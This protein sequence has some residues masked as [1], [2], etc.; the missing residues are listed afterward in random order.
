MSLEQMIGFSLALLVMAVG[1]AGSV[2]PGVPST[3]LVLIAAL[4]HKWIFGAASA[5]WA[6]IVVLAGLM[7]LSVVM[8]FLATWLGAKKLGATWK[9]ILGALVGVVVGIF[10]GLPG[11]VVGPFLGAMLF[12]MVGGSDWRKAAKAGAGALIGLFIGTLGKFACAVAMTGLFA[13]NVLAR[14]AR[15]GAAADVVWMAN[16]LG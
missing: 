16:L 5:D 14:T 8:D 6:V 15:G 13:M 7:V 12:E 9:G 10:F 1:V 2:L 11:I 3:P 4:L